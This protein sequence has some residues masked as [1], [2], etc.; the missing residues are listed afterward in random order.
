MKKKSIVALTMLLCICS[1][2]AIGCNN[3][4]RKQDQ[5]NRLKSAHEKELNNEPMTE[6]EYNTLKSFHDWEDSQSEK[7][8]SEWEQ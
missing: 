7:T 6:E 2:F 4:D 1:G 8:Y 3:S 5:L